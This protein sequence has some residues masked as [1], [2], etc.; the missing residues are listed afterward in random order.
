MVRLSNYLLSRCQHQFEIVRK[1]R[2]NFVVFRWVGVTKLS[3]SLLKKSVHDLLFLTHKFL[4]FF[5]AVRLT[6]DVDNGA[7]MRDAIQDGRGNRNIGKDFIPLGEGLVGGEDGGGFLIASGNELEEQV[8]TLDI[9]LSMMSI[10]YLDRTLSLS[11]RRFSKWA[12]LSCSM[13]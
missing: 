11:G 6:L 2:R 12:F 1:R 4:A 7:V 3:V 8:C 13:S 9:I 10:L 5:Q